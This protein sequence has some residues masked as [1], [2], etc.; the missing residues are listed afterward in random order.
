MLPLLCILLVSG[1]CCRKL[2]EISNTALEDFLI[3]F[4]RN[5]AIEVCTDS[6]AV[7][8][9]T[10]DSAV[11]RG[12]AFDCHH[13]SVRV[14]V[15]IHSWVAVQ[16]DILGCN[17]SVFCQLFNECRRSN[18]PTFAV[19]NCNGGRPLRSHTATGTWWKP[20]WLLPA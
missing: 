11:W 12:N 2:P 10:E 20:L 9:L 16:I 19:R 17:L 1:G 13:G 14:V 4:A 6:F 18:E 3:L 15:N 5:I 8:H 7:S